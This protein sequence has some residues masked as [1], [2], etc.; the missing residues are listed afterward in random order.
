MRILQPIDIG[1]FPLEWANL[2]SY[3]KSDAFRIEIYLKEIDNIVE[4]MVALFYNLFASELS[5]IIVFDRLW[6]DFCLDT[7]KIAEDQHDYDLSNR[8]KTS[9]EYLKMLMESEVEKNFSGCCR[10]NDWNV[11]LKT[12]LI[13]IVNHEAPYS[14]LFIDLENDF[15]F[16]FHHTGS[17]GLYYRRENDVTKNIIEKA[18]RYYDLRD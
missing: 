4:G 13:C 11:F 5:N 8:S 17:I 10:C 15:F 7:W 3:R 1:G 12:I 18:S 9:K 2:E 16:Y 14:P 6:W